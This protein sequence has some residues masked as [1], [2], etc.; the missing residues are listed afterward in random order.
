M[1]LKSAACY[2]LIF[3]LYIRL[4][5]KQIFPKEEPKTFPDEKTDVLTEMK[6][7]ISRCDNCFTNEKEKMHLYAE[8]DR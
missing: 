7:E 4:L 6:T 1:L 2:M 5:F 3:P 8:I